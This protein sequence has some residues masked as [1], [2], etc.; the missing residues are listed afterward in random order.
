M[1]DNG[2]RNPLFIDSIKS[3]QG[4]CNNVFKDSEGM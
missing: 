4:G 1:W 3:S 2:K